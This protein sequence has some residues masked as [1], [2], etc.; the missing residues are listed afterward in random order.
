MCYALVHLGKTKGL[1]KTLM[2]FL[3]SQKTEWMTTTCNHA[4]YAIVDVFTQY[5]TVLQDVLLSDLYEQLYWCVQQ[6]ETIDD[7]HYLCSCP[8]GWNSIL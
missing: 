8:L 7:I 5:Y 3:F 6:G 2:Y 1:G 4:L